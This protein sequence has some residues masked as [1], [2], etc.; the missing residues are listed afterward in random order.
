[1]LG[2]AFAAGCAT[3]VD[4]TEGEL[5]EICS[6][7]GTTCGGVSNPV[8]SAGSAATGG[9]GSSIGG[10]GNISNGGTY[11][12]SVGGSSGSINSGGGQAGSSNSATGGSSGSGASTGG[13]GATQPLA[14]GDCLAQSDVVIRYRDRSNGAATNNQ[15]TMV[16]SVQNMGPDF[17]LTDLT[18]R[19]W[20]TSEVG[21][22]F[23]FNVDYATFDGQQN[24]SG[25][26]TVTFGQDLGSNYA[27]IGFSQAG[28]VGTAGVRE[29]QLRFYAD[30]YPNMDQSNDF[31]FLSG[32]PAD[33]PNPNITPYVNGAQ[34]GGCVPAL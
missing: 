20:F 23:S 1:M 31:S 8:G 12:A 14:D 16:L 13:T 6:E 19:Y 9:S 4:V 25:S 26:T 11:S 17:D 29:V 32:A 27:E 28:T 18:I 2:A 3:G 33:T 5:N 10:S 15:I 22:A 34:V 7:P 30:G 24:L 21:T